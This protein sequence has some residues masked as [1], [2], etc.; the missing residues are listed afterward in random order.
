VAAP[1]SDPA[2]K[3]AESEPRDVGI[4]KL[5][6]VNT[7]SSAEL[8]LLPGIGPVMAGRI[9]EDRTIYGLYRSPADL[10]RVK[11]IG[12]KTLEKLTPLIR[13]D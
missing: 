5:V 9:I 7:A 8:Q 11:G 1:E 4:Q 3:P 10:D 12:P 2:P 6:N 13:F